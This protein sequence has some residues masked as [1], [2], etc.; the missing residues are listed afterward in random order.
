MTATCLAKSISISKEIGTV[1]VSAL[2]DIVSKAQITKKSGRIE[3]GVYVNPDA[4][5]AGGFGG[6]LFEGKLGYFVEIAFDADGAAAGLTATTYTGVITSTSINV[7]DND[8]ITERATILLGV[9][10]FG[11]SGSTDTSVS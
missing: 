7:A 1:D 8:A 11:T 6:Y 3:L 10:G 4:T 2:C 5:G 9:N